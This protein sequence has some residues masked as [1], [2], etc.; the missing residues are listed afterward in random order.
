MDVILEAPMEAPPAAVL[1]EVAD[2]PSYPTW[3]GMVKKV[4][5][6]GDGWLIDL[7]VRMGP[8]TKTKRVRMVRA[9]DE[10]GSAP[11]LVR[12]TRRERDR[13]DHGQWELEGI[14]EPAAGEGP[15]TLR[16]RL[17][18]D[19]SSPL[20]GMLEPLLKSEIERSAERLRSRLAAGP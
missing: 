3:H 8:F 15:C 6:D 12:F 18:Y 9:E 20:A 2:L 10:S 16:F 14:V 19:G 1:A 5:P 4:V 17:R 7:G 13:T 11:G